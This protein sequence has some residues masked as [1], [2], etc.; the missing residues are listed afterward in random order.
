METGSTTVD[1][2]RLR[3]PWG[4]VAP[5]GLDTATWVQRR[6][7]CQRHLSRRHGEHRP[8]GRERRGQSGWGRF[9]APGRGE[10]HDQNSDEGDGKR[11]DLRNP[12]AR[13]APARRPPGRNT[14]AGTGTAT[15]RCAQLQ[16]IR[17]SSTVL[18]RRCRY[19]A[20]TI[21]T[22]TIEL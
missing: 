1:P 18:G 8:V 7:E 3:T 12:A 13:R 6:G 21:G 14:H 9:R 15:G 22:K 4:T 19:I 17:S 16:A 2:S 20:T 5:V 10:R 11:A